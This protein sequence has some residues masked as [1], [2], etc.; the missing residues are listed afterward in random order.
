[1]AADT[2]GLMD[3]LSIERAHLI[4]ESMG[5]MIAQLI[6]LNYPDR[7]LTL[8][9]MCSS[10]GAFD[11]DLPPMPDEIIALAMAPLPES[12]AERVEHLVEFYRAL[13]GTTPFDEQR[14]RT[15]IETDMDRGFNP[16]PAHALVILSA[17]SRREALGHL[18]LPVLVIHGDADPLFPYEHGVATAKAVPGA[19]LVAVADAG[20]VDLCWRV[21]DLLP[22]ILDQL[23]SA[24]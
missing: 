23:T 6:A 21:D 14:N 17:P 7:I 12:R 11:P 20:H 4:G 13:S 22:P 19:R 2:V 8:T 9:S 16:T 3:A 18:D 10:P 24:R 1:M 15:L 5:G